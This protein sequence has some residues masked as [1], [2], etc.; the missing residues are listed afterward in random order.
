M[1]ITRVSNHFDIYASFFWYFFST[2]FRISLPTDVSTLNVFLRGAIFSS[3]LLN[4]C[5]GGL[6]TKNTYYSIDG[7]EYTQERREADS[8]R[9]R[10]DIILNNLKNFVTL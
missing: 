9:K 6:S 2:I 5:F 4:S 10:K 1:K 7:E 8:E 3:H